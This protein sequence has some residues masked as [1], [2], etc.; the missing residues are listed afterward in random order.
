MKTEHL[1][2]I[3]W[4]LFSILKEPK[5]NP[6]I[7]LNNYLNKN[8]DKITLVYSDAHLGDLAKTSDELS[9]TRKSDLNYLSAKTKDLA[10][11][12][13]F[14]RDYIDV[15]N[16]NALE[17]YETNVY[18]NSTAP[19]VQ[20]QSVVK[21]MTDNYGP[22]RDDIIKTHFKLDPKSI[23]NFSVSQLDELIKMI[24]IGNSL[25]EFIEFGLQLR[26]DTSTN[27]LT[28]VDY[29]TTAYMN[30]DL[31]GFFPDSMNEKGDFSNLL[32]DSKHSAYGSLC[33]TFITND[34]KCYHKSKF[35]FEYFK[36]N[37]KLIKTCKIKNGTAELEKELNSLTE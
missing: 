7:V 34:N 33:K 11:V 35:L 25:K 20:W 28:Y 3:D 15:E 17:F 1:T 4:N 36:S 10:I 27:P 24:G 37:S 5:L 18:D 9:G 2:Y 6:H 19:L 32:N 29:Y 30:L 23:C 13:Y 8:S 14:G 26:G 31:I 22:L 16:R 12:S 21:Q